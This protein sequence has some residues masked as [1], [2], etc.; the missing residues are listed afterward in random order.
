M[1]SRIANHQEEI[2]F[3]SLYLNLLRYVKKPKEDVLDFD[4]F[5]TSQYEVSRF[6]LLVQRLFN[7]FYMVVF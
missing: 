4:T 6:I 2:G 7:I 3:K 5:E 1:W